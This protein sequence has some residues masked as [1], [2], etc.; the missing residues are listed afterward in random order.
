M[1]HPLHY[2]T[3]NAVIAVMLARSF[4]REAQQSGW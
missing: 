3:A 4:L 2:T 1:A